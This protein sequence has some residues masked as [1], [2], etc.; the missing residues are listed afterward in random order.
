[1]RVI[2]NSISRV[3]A[4]D[5]VLGWTKFPADLYM[6]GM[7]YAKVVWSERP[8]ARIV[9][10]DL[11]EAKGLGV[12]TIL[13]AQDVAHNEYGLIENDQAVLAEGKVRCVRDPVALVMAESEGSAQR[14]ADAVKVIYEDLPVV[15]D[16][17]RAMEPQAPLVHEEKGSNILHHFRVRKGEVETGFREAAVVVEGYYHSP[18]LE[19][20]YLQPEAGLGY[21]DQEGRVVVHTAGQ[22][23]HEDRHQIAHALDLPE[24]RVRVI[25][26]PVGGAFGGREDISVQILLA[27]ATWKSGRPVKMVW[28]REESIRGHHKRHPFYI[29]CKSGARGDGLLTAAEVELVADAGAYASTSRAVLANAV[30]LCTG[31][32]QIPH[33]SVDGY[34][35]DTNNLPAGAVRG[36]GANQANFAAEMQMAKLAQALGMDPVEFRLKNLLEEGARLSVQSEVPAGVGIK[37]TLLEVAKKAEWPRIKERKGKEGLMRGV[38]VACGWKNVGYSFGSPERSTAQ[39]ELFGQGGIERAVVKCGTA[40]VGQGVMTILAQLAA[41]TLGLNLERVEVIGVDTDSTPSAG[42]SSASRQAFMSGNAVRGACLAAQ[43]AWERG[44][45]PAEATYEYRAPSTTPFDPQTGECRP[46]FS[47]GYGSQIV[48]VEVDG[49][50]GEVALK[51]VFA[52]HDV[53]RALNPAAIEGQIEG[54]VVMA[55]GHALLEEFIQQEGLIQTRLLSQYLIPTSMDIP[56]EIVPIILEKADPLGPFGAR[57]VGE[58]T[59][60]P[61]VP[62]V[63]DAIHD[64]TGLWFDQLPVTAEKVYMALRAQKERG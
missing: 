25:Y 8:H 5:K 43:E 47:Y 3:D 9:D 13:T 4:W 59:T 38:G 48:E 27:L 56:E 44:E 28:S 58:M 57:G 63:L 32:Y 20:A 6:E 1:M 55:Q 16:P 45:R 12:T 54:G 60:L 36:F 26:T 33:V 62:A 51:R 35:V 18:H 34:A 29:K 14:G 21:I 42:S 50:T 53:G 41:E 61:L 49:E 30:L 46:N 40:E 52:V 37:E 15:S 2:G 17:R 31:P 19:H 24:E 7:L 39:V 11:S 22:W 64:A 10:I 23:A